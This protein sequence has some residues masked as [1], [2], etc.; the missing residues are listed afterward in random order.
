MAF[1]KKSYDA[2]SLESI[3]IIIMEINGIDYIA[4]ANILYTCLM[5]QLFDLIFD[6]KL[7]QIF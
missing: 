4:I 2:S 1:P 6:L 7:M 5:M 3:I